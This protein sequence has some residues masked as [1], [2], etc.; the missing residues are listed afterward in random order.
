MSPQYALSE[1]RLIIS[2]CIYIALVFSSQWPICGILAVLLVFSSDKY[3]IRQPPQI[4]P[5]FKEIIVGAFSFSALK[6]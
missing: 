6:C 2:H 4:Q 3:E 1:V 5:I